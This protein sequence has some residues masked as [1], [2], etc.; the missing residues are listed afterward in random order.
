M[1]EKTSYSVWGVMRNYNI[2]FEFGTLLKEIRRMSQLAFQNFCDFDK[3][4][5]KEGNQLGFRT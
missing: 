3:Q 5:Q 4:I 1:D 2:I